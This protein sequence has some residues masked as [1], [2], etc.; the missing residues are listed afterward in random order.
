MDTKSSQYCSP[1]FDT[2]RASC[3]SL[4]ARCHLPLSVPHPVTYPPMEGLHP[5]EHL[6][7]TDSSEHRNP[8]AWKNWQAQGPPHFPTRKVE[9]VSGQALVHLLFC[10]LA[11]PSALVILLGLRCT[12]P[13][14]TPTC[15]V[16]AVHVFIPAPLPLTN[17]GSSLIP[18]TLKQVLLLIKLLYQCHSRDQEPILPIPVQIRSG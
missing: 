17:K 10:F 6:L 2:L 8:P 3:A 7:S 12:S 14:S 16:F 5:H 13:F 9:L 4:T 1:L 18:V 15:Y 11:T